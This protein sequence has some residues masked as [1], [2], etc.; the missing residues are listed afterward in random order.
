MYIL[1]HSGQFS[2]EEFHPS[3]GGKLD[4]KNRWLLL[5]EVIPWMTLESQD[6]HQFSAKPG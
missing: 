6:A 3:F 1:Q 2:S 5:H 4:P